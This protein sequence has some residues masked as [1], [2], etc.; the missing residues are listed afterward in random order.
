MKKQS[1]IVQLISDLNK[2]LDFIS[3]THNGKTIEVN[4]HV[5]NILVMLANEH[6]DYYSIIKAYSN[7]YNSDI[8]TP[9]THTPEEMA[10]SYKKI[11]NELKH[12][13]E[14]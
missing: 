5:Y 11:L 14:N 9:W 1:H 3:K 6:K 13:K 7:L 10:E 2:V 12:D 8:V 4:Y